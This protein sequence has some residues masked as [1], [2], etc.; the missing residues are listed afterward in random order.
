MPCR[1]LENLAA[2]QTAIARE[3]N[4]AV[5]AMK[6][7]KRAGCLASV[8]RAA[9]RSIAREANHAAVPMLIPAEPALALVLGQRVNGERIAHQGKRAAMENVPCI[10][11]FVAPIVTAVKIHGAVAEEPQSRLI[12]RAARPVLGNHAASITTVLQVI[13]VVVFCA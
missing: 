10:A 7:A 13:I 5:A 12:V 4:S 6:V 2:I 11:L 8:S 1:V 3:T 9:T